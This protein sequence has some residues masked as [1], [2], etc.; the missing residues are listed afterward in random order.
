MNRSVLLLAML[1]A[2]CHGATHSATPSH[3]VAV[4]SEVQSLKS[5]E[6]KSPPPTWTLTVF[7][8]P[9]DTYEIRVLD[10]DHREV[11]VLA[12]PGANAPL[13]ASELLRSEDFNGDGYPDIL[14]RGLS[15]GASA[16]SS[17]VIFVYLPEKGRF[18]E[19]AIFEHE[20][21][22]SKTAH[23]CIAVEHRAENNF[24]YT[25]DHYCWESGMWSFKG[26]KD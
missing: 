9:H 17:E 26:S 21:E 16:L 5:T 11:Q 25:K 3:I 7:P 6:A 19:A 12:G 15:A 23:G 24:T 20:G 2:S 22:V 8:G 1:M 10:S 4:A 14:A 13:D 18:T